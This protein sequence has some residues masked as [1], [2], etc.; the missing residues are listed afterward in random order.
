MNTALRRTLAHSL[1]R[2]AM[3]C[4]DE[5]KR[6]I[7]FERLIAILLAMQVPELQVAALQVSLFCTVWATFARK[8]QCGAITQFLS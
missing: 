1:R 7:S 6:A 2:F 8:C 4:F 3:P 5:G